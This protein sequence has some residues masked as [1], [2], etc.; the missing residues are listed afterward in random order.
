MF[1]FSPFWELH[2]VKPPAFKVVHELQ[3]HHSEKQ[4]PLKIWSAFQRIKG[5]TLC[6]ARFWHCFLPACNWQGVLR[7][8]TTCPATGPGDNETED[9]L[10]MH[11]SDHFPH[12]PSCT[13]LSTSVNKVLP[14]PDR[15]HFCYTKSG[16]RSLVG[17]EELDVLA[18]TRPMPNQPLPKISKF[19]GNKSSAVTRNPEN[20]DC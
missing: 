2:P 8:K 9:F 12:F 3:P 19:Q 11:Q 16:L 7:V 13:T 20:N 6:K 18:C 14:K 4:P 1:R 17:P 15:W 5:L 10:Q